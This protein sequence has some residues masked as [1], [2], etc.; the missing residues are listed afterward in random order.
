MKSLN[1]VIANEKETRDLWIQRYEEEQKNH[2]ETNSGL[3]QARSE[4]K[5]QVLL[6]KNSAKKTTTGKEQK[7]P[8]AVGF[9]FVAQNLLPLAASWWFPWVAAAGTAIN[10][11]TLVFTAAT[12][13][14][15]LNKKI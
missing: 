7:A 6:L 4:L 11:F 12:V 8:S 14:I 10:L 2:T 1:E 9:D 3:L 5:D 15:F 13:V